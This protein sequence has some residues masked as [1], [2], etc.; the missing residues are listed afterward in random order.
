[1]RKKMIL[2]SILIVAIFLSIFILLKVVSNS[3]VSD[4]LKDNSQI[5]SSNMLDIEDGSVEF[6]NAVNALNWF[7]NNDD[8]YYQVKIKENIKKIKEINNEVNSPMTLNQKLLSG[9]SYE[10]NDGIKIR[11]GF[12]NDSIESIEKFISM[13]ASSE[14]ESI[15]KESYNNFDILH[16]N[17][18]SYTYACKKLNNNNY[19]YVLVDHED[20]SM[21]YISICK[22]YIDK[23]N[24]NKID[25]KLVKNSGYITKYKEGWFSVKDGYHQYLDKNNIKLDE[26]LTLNLKGYAVA[27]VNLDKLGNN[28]EYAIKMMSEEYD[29]NDKKYIS[30]DIAKFDKNET[31]EVLESITNNPKSS[32]KELTLNNAKVVLYNY[33]YTQILK[34][35]TSDGYYVFM[36]E[37]FEGFED[38]LRNI[39]G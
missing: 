29:E 31:C 34:Y 5:L 9:F 22:K 2:I 20:S 10:F 11:I 28:Y 1:M 8:S 21:D 35:D 27:Q 17:K 33:N 18:A 24:V 25:S 39:L 37:S 3:K 36:S 32:S 19:F 6:D 23:I 15:Q 26:N 7:Y 4:D 14:E 38:L 12:S 30:F 13:L 16:F